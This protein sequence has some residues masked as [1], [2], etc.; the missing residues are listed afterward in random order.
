MRLDETPL[1]P[2]AFL[3]DVCWMT[4]VD[5]PSHPTHQVLR[6]QWYALHAYSLRPRIGPRGWSG[7]RMG[8]VLF[9]AVFASATRWRTPPTAS[10]VA[11]FL[12]LESAP[13]TIGTLPAD[14]S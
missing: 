5:M 12:M 6:R 2:T 8:A 13:P 3:E 1:V 9:P 11:P 14:A 10:A 4:C 7:A